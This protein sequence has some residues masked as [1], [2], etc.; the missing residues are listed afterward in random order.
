MISCVLRCIVKLYGNKGTEN[1]K[2]L[3]LASQGMPNTKIIDGTEVVPYSLPFMVSIQRRFNNNYTHT[4]SGSILDTT[5]ILTSA[6]CVKGYT[7]FFSN[8]PNLV[9]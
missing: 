2:K 8:I 4:C 5:T 3:L 6:S 7:L 1:E 9:L